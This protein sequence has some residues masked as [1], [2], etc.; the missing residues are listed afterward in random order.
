MAVAACLLVL[1]RFLLM[2]ENARLAALE[3]EDMQLS[4]KE[5]VRLQRTADTEG[6]SVAEARQL[7]KGF[8]FPI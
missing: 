1:L 4:E 5:M 7:Q 2:K 6:I 8:R 3:N